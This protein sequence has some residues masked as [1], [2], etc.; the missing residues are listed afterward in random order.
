MGEIRGSL[1]D[2]GLP[3]GHPHIISGQYSRYEG[4]FPLVRLFAGLIL[5]VTRPSLRGIGRIPF[6]SWPRFVTEQNIPA[7]K[8]ALGLHLLDGGGVASEA[9][10]I[11][12]RE[13]ALTPRSFTPRSCITI[14]ATGGWR[15]ASY[16]H[17][18]NVG[19]PLRMRVI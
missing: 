10:L 3:S 8:K 16:I 7:K 5:C 11:S 13:R 4:P 15:A 19:P 6:S 9:V 18:E 2:A 14:V 17:P 12:E 1:L